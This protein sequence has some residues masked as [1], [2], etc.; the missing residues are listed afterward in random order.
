MDIDDP[1]K[2]LAAL[3]KLEEEKAKRLN[4]KVEAGEAVVV[5]LMVTG[6]ENRG[7]A[8]ECRALEG[9]AHRAA[10]KRR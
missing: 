5:Q 9:M 10:E 4:A 2:L 3:D 1:E 6:E 8:C 7:G